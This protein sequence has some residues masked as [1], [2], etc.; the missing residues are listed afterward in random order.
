MGILDDFGEGISNSFN[1]MADNMERGVDRGVEQSLSNTFRHAVTGATGDRAL[2]NDA[3]SV[4]RNIGRNATQD[5]DRPV[6][7]QRQIDNAVSRTINNGI[8]GVLSG[9]RR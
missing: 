5:Q 6:Y 4:G 2:G 9:P 7:H 1:R 8:R 3:A